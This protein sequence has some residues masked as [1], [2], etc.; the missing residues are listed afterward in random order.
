[1]I[2]N[3]IEKSKKSRYRWGI[4]VYVDLSQGPWKA[5]VWSLDELEIW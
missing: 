4:G 5:T 2:T 1:M 3:I